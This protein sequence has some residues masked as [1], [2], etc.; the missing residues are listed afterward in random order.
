M[1]SRLINPALVAMILVVSPGCVSSRDAQ[2]RRVGDEHIARGLDC[3]AESNFIRDRLGVL[4]E[5]ELSAKLE[6]CSLA[7]GVDCFAAEEALDDVLSF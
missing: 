5:S 3:F 6:R 2:I 1:A 4:E 7:I